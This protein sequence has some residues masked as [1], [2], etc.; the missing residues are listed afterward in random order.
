MIDWKYFRSLLIAIGSL[1][2]ATI[3]IFWSWAKIVNEKITAAGSSLRAWLSLITL[4]L[5]PVTIF[6][7]WDDYQKLKSF[8]TPIEFELKV[9]RTLKDD[10]SI[11]GTNTGQFT[12]ESSTISLSL[13]NIEKQKDSIWISKIPLNPMFFDF[14]KPSEKM[15]WNLT[16]LPTLPVYGTITL[17]C[18]NC[19]QSGYFLYFSEQNSKIESFIYK[20]DGDSIFEGHKFLSNKK[21]YLEGLFPKKNR[22]LI[23]KPKVR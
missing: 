12:A 16:K 5:L 3:V 21:N 10:I 4:I 17:N 20:M 22:I 19:K 7:L 14:T 15:I 18:R 13:Q 2:L 8:W 23:K 11:T 9:T 6:T 1:P